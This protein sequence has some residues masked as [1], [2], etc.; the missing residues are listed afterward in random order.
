MMYI[1]N[2]CHSTHFMSIRRIILFRH[3]PSMKVQGNTFTPLH[4]CVVCNVVKCDRNISYRVVRRYSRLEEQ[5]GPILMSRGAVITRCC[6]CGLKG[7]IE[8]S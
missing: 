6:T 8:K 5:I 2:R 4:D 7:C 1:K 3:H